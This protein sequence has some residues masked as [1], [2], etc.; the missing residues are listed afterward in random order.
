[1]TILDYLDS[2]LRQS[3]TAG[4]FTSACPTRTK[5]LEAPVAKRLAALQRI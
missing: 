1:M 2:R 4:L 5:D 3:T